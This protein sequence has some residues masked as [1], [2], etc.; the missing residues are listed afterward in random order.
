MKVCSLSLRLFDGGLVVLTDYVHLRAHV[1]RM[2][3]Q[4]FS[5]ER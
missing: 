5:A 2:P 1:L 3:S 4:N